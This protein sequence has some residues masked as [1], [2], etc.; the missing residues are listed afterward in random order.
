MKILTLVLFSFIFV[1]AGKVDLYLAL[2]EKARLEYINK[3]TKLSLN[4]INNSLNLWY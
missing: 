2:E 4:G 3:V 1:Q